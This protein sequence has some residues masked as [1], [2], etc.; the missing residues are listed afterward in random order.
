M[1]PDVCPNCGEMVPDN[2]KACPECGACEETGWSEDAKADQ[3]GIPREEFDYEGYLREEFADEKP[4]RKLQP[5]WSTTAWV[6]AGIF[7]LGAGT[8]LYWAIRALLKK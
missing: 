5:V 2:A 4:K 6:M 3:L 1:T 7:I 8:I